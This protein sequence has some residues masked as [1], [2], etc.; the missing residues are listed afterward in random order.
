MVNT[1]EH[2]TMFTGAGLHAIATD[3]AEEI[4][5]IL[6]VS[7]LGKSAAATR[8]LN[9][10]KQFFFFLKKDF[11]LCIQCCAVLS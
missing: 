6:R 3:Q 7:S 2:S 8:S 4:A 1:D 10:S 9:R 5:E 11:L